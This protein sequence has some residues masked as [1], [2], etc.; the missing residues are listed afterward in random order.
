[1]PKMTIYEIPPAHSSN[2]KS[3]PVGFIN[4]TLTPSNFQTYFF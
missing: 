1:M 4:L 3:P 2:G